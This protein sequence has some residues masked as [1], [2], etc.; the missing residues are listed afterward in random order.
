MSFFSA[1]TQ[2]VT[3]RGNLLE[4]GTRPDLGGPESDHEF[5]QDVERIA[6]RASVTPFSATLASLVEDWFWPVSIGPDGSLH[7]RRDG[8]NVQVTV[9]TVRAV[10]RRTDVAGQLGIEPTAADLAAA[11][12][13]VARR[14]RAEAERQAVADDARADDDRRERTR[15][16]ELAQ[17]KAD[18][19]R[20]LAELDAAPAP[21]VVAR[22]VPT[23]P[24]AMW[25]KKS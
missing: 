18:L 16:A 13:V 8:N 10:L 20:A 22:T 19:L 12:A 2:A 9:P 25:R 15:D 23:P 7:G 4:G 11:L 3:P 14:A 1:N 5:R 21:A 6:G 17:L 24:K